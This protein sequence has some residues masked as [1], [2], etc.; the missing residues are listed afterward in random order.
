MI[1]A[2]KNILVED[3]N[4]NMTNIERVN[5]PDLE[6]SKTDVKK[7]DILDISI[8]DKVKEANKPNHSTANAMEEVDK[9]SIGIGKIN[10]KKVDK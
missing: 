5:K 9:S 1:Q 8:A 6:T 4:I 7:V 10:I 2:R 3:P